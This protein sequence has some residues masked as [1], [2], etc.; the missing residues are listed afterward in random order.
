MRQL[1]IDEAIALTVDPAEPLVA[2]GIEVSP[3]E[4]YALV[5][6]GRWRDWFKVAG[7]GGWG[8]NWLARF[9]RLPGRAFFLLCGV[10][11]RDDS[12]AFEIGPGREWTV[13]AK[14]PVDRQLYLF[15]NDWCGMYW[16]NRAL[17]EEDGGP[18][19]LTITRRA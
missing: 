8:G 15:A 16:N 14:L 3:G 9:N 4:R 18:L 17:A 1:A 12:N 2:S 5:A 7:P 10:V 11:G 6:R 19:R 13:P